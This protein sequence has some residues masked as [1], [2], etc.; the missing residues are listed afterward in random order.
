MM[1]TKSNGMRY[2]NKERDYMFRS[3]IF[4]LINICIIQSEQLEPKTINIIYNNRDYIMKVLTNIMPDYPYTKKGQRKIN[5]LKIFQLKNAPLIE[6][7]KQKE[8]IIPELINVSYCFRRYN[9]VTPFLCDTFYTHFL[10]SLLD[11]PDDRK[12]NNRKF[13]HVIAGYSDDNENESTW[14]NDAVNILTNETYFTVT[15]SFSNE[16]QLRLSNN[17]NH[18]KQINN[19][20]CLTELPEKLRISL[21][22][23]DSLALWA[24]VR[25]GDSVALDGIFKEY[26]DFKIYQNRHDFVLKFITPLIN[27]LSFSSRD[28]CIKMLI[29]LLDKEIHD[30]H[31]NEECESPR[32]K[33]LLNIA[34][35]Y[36]DNILFGS[37]FEFLNTGINCICFSEMKRQFYKDLKE[38][39]KTQFDISLNASEEQFYFLKD[40]SGKNKYKE[41]CALERNEFNNI[42]KTGK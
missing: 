41:E 28:T 3:L 4:L 13:K 10:V 19:L 9:K 33:I 25:L 37:K 18:N 30:I 24:K 40:C 22:K 39:I 29:F 6:W 42:I 26:K 38:W 1:F 35:N 5:E 7:D 2:K 14:V 31:D 17:K 27:N 21:L 34:R 12:K 20:L 32:Q 36:P 8:N 16:I 15:K 23:N 11:L